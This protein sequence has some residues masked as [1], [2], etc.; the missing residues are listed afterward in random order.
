M[1]KIKKH[2][3]TL[4]VI[5]DPWKHCKCLD[6]A[7]VCNC[8]DAK[9][10]KEIWCDFRFICKGMGVKWKEIERE[11][12]RVIEITRNKR[13]GIKLKIKYGNGVCLGCVLKKSKLC[14]G[15]E[16]CYWI[17]PYKHIKFDKVYKRWREWSED[18]EKQARRIKIKGV[19][20]SIPYRF[21][22]C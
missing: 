21:I 16:T 1:R 10:C 17:S 8:R 7:L 22:L 3:L 6:C 13:K 20:R 9:A 12:I 19:Y 2:R 18:E 4:K 11:G 5:A 14:K 15:F